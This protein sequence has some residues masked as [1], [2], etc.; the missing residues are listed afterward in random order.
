MARPGLIIAFIFATLPA[1]VAQEGLQPPRSAVFENHYLKINL[2]PGWTVSRIEPSSSFTTVTAARIAKGGYVLEIDPIF[3]HASGVVGGR[4]GEVIGDKPSVKAVMEGVEQPAGGFECG[5]SDTMRLGPVSMT[6]FFTDIAKKTTTDGNACKFPADGR[7]AWFASYDSGTAPGMEHEYAITLTYDATDVDKLPKRD[8]PELR[9]VFSEVAEMLKTLVL[10][11]PLSVSRIEPAS[12]PPGSTVTVY[13]SGFRLPGCDASVIFA[14]FPNNPMHRP[15]VS[16]DGTSLT[17]QVPVSVNKISC[18]KGHVDIGEHC[19]PVPADHDTA[20]DCPPDDTHTNF[21]GAPIAPGTYQIFVQ[22]FSSEVKSEPFRFTVTRQSTPVSIS[23]VYPNS[24]VSP[25]DV[26]TVRGSG[27]TPTANT[28]TIGSAAVTDVPSADGLTLTFHAPAPAGDSFIR[29][30][31]YYRLFV[32][33]SRGPSN[34][35]TFTYR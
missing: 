8:S 32:S 29:G 26:V 20:N 12:G 15:S 5:T 7:S 10:K 6:T 31:R 1:A 24:I 13:G 34:G 30:L 2:S 17:F 27:F 33:N 9:R 11:P 21:C 35:I 19:V 18:Q 28:V 16:A 4:F 3:G 22:T 14:D 25:G 23:L